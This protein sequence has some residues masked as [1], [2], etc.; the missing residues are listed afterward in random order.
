MN[1]RGLVLVVVVVLV[2]AIGGLFAYQ[3]F[4]ASPA[5]EAATTP[6]ADL[7]ANTIAVDTET[8]F[9]AAEGE[10]VPLRH[11][12]LA[13]ATTGHVADLLVEE[14]Q[15]V[16]ADSP[17]LR[18]ESAD[19]EIAL[20]QARA[21][22]SEAEANLAAAE[23]GVGAAEI[24]VQAAELGVR[25]ANVQL[26]IARADPTPEQVALQESQ[27]ALANAQ[28]DRAVAGQN[29]VLESPLASLIL[30]A[31]AELDAAEAQAIPI[32]IRLD[33]LRVQDEPDVEALDTAEHQY[34]AAQARIEAA[35]VALE[36][37]RAG[38]S[39]AER[40]AAG[41]G[42]A[43]ATAQRDAAQAQLDMLLAG[44]QV[45][46][47]TAAEAGVHQ[48]EAALTE[49]QQSVGQA[50]AAVGQAAAGAEAARVAV[51]AAEDELARMTLLAPFPGTVADL[52]VEEGEVVSAGIPVITLADFD[53]WM[54]ETTDLTELDVVAIAVGHPASVQI[55]ALPGETLSGRVV[56]I[57]PASQEVRGDVTYA[58]KVDLDEQTELPL[59]WGMTVFVT[60]GTEADEQLQPASAA[61]TAEAVTTGGAVSAEGVLE[62]LRSVELSFLTGG[63][64]AELLVENGRQVNTGDPLIRLDSGPLENA[65]AQVEAAL[66]TAEAGQKAAE[67][68]LVVAQSRQAGAEAAVAAAEAQLALIQGGPRSEEI[69]AAEENLAAAEAGVVQAVG[70]RDASVEVSV[71][72]VRAAEAE[73]AAAEA[74]LAPLQEAYETILDTCFELPDGG[75]TCPLLG[76][77]EET[78]RFQLETAQARLSA[79]QAALE[80]ARNGPTAAQQQAADAAV[81]VAIAQ[82]NVA[83]A[84]LAL[85]QAGATSQ[86]IEEAQLKVEQMGLGLTEVE[87]EVQA[88]EAAV[89]QAQAGVVS[90]QAAVESAQKALERMTVRAPFPG[91]V[92]NLTVEVGEMVAPGTPVAAVADMSGWQVRTTDLVD[93]DIANVAVGQPVEVTLDAIP[94]ETLRGTVWD[95]GRVAELSQGD[96]TY[97]VVI[98]LSDYP[99]LPLRWGMS[100]LVSTD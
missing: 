79:A 41:G 57:A 13:F 98:A 26:S 67:A 93:L 50:Q 45:Q 74:A 43:I 15:L 70:N 69:A 23:A 7:A 51:S 39:D 59:R 61:T 75:E 2:L 47:V 25:A 84:Q 21:A 86:Q 91:I 14:G 76:P 36:E 37:L 88:A 97:S 66:K 4:L 6:S 27:I 81:A 89:M 71:A 33:E 94:D 1:L 8:D 87:A 19:E 77:P 12:A 99:D 83:Q 55:D 16:D 63:T 34:A 100:V 31:E 24:G 44:S 28:L 3:R 92:A 64:V 53:G 20:A 10:I 78:V 11:A 30:A 49:A 48:A 60:I 38:A 65:L 52:G 73:V 17:L 62:P 90:A 82:R 72:Q 56:D 32:R 80:E 35:R 18:L 9:V 22:Q 58:V 5:R 95:I 40:Q 68:Q 96:V 29:V 54:V 85:L 42:V 46:Q